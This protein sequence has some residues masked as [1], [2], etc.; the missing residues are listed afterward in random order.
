MKIHDF[1]CHPQR[2]CLQFGSVGEVESPR[3]CCL[4][5]PSFVLSDLEFGVV[6]VVSGGSPSGIVVISVPFVDCDLSFLQ[7]TKTNNKTT[8]RAISKTPPRTTPT[9]ST[10]LSSE[11]EVVVAV[12]SGQAA[13]FGGLEQN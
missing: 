4:L 9:I 5:D 12:N 3:P 7:L 13:D 1:G 8:I 6:V 2:V 10:L 11:Q